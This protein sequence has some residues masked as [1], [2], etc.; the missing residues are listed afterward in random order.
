M[1]PSII[2][3][4]GPI[5]EHAK[6]FLIEL[7]CGLNKKSELPIQ[8]NTIKLPHSFVELFFYSLELLNK[9]IPV[10]P[11]TLVTKITVIANA[12]SDVE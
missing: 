9:N 10:E 8:P 12:T 6:N 11:N 5:V 7:N 4:N 1:I 3:E 2:Q